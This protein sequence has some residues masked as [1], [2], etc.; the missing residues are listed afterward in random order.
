M[1]EVRALTVGAGLEAP[2]TVKQQRILSESAASR[3]NPSRKYLQIHGF[4]AMRRLNSLRE[5]T[6]NQFAPNREP[7]RGEQ[8]IN[9]R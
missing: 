7:I 3:A 8:V 6:G 5:R 1:G 4:A 2:V 9:S